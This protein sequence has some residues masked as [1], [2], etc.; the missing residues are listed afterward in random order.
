MQ[1]AVFD[2]VEVEFVD[3]YELPPG[4]FYPSVKLIRAV[5]S[6]LEYG[7]GAPSLPH[8]RDPRL[9][10]SVSVQ[11]ASVEEE[12]RFLLSCVTK[13]EHLPFPAG[14]GMASPQVNRHL[15]LPARRMF[16]VHLD[17]EGLKQ[18]NLTQEPELFINPTVEGI[19]CEGYNDDIERCYSVPGV[20]VIARRF[21]VVLLNGVRIEGPSARVVQHENDHLNATLCVDRAFHQVLYYV[22][23]ELW[24]L[25]KRYYDE[26]RVYEWPFIFSR[27]QLNAMWTGAWNFQAYFHLID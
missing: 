16:A 25:F 19:S 17:L 11:D 21:N 27:E 6:Y 10:R 23:P 20:A 9:I 24:P 18:E 4:W 22:P 3:N 2:G 8:L 7:L 5:R 12:R 1:T 26:G 13:G 14:V 15:M